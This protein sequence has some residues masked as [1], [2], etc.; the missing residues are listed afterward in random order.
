[1]RGTAYWALAVALVAAGPALCQVRVGDV[2]FGHEGHYREMHSTQVVVELINEGQTGIQGTAFVEIPGESGAPYR[3]TQRVEMPAQSH[4]RVNLYPYIGSTMMLDSLSVG[5]EPDRGSRSATAVPAEAEPLTDLLVLVCNESTPPFNF[6]RAIDTTTWMS[7]PGGGT[8]VSGVPG[9]GSYSKADVYVCWTTTSDLP[10][11]WK[12]LDDVDLLIMADFSPEALSPAQQDAILQWVSTGGRL[13]ITGGEDYRRVS[14]SFLA[15]YL[16]VNVT[17]ARTFAEGLP[18]LTTKFGGTMEAAPTVVTD[19]RPVRGFIWASQDGTP[20]LSSSTLGTG[21]L[22][23]A[24]FSFG[25]RPVLHW[26]GADDVISFILKRGRQYQPG[27]VGHHSDA[28]AASALSTQ[29]GPTPPSFQIISLFLLLYIVCLVPVNYLVLRK[30][31]RRELAWVTTP[32][33]VVVFSVA[34][35]ALGF[36]LKGNAVQLG[37]AGLFEI[38]ATTGAGHAQGYYALFSPRKHSYDISFGAERVVARVPRV[39]GSGWAGGFTE[40]A[41][42]DTPFQVASGERDQIEGLTVQMWDQKVFTARGPV[43]LEA[44]MPGDLR[45]DGQ[46]CLGG[47]L[48]NQLGFDLQGCVIAFRDQTTSLGDIPNGQ[49]VSVSMGPARQRFGHEPEAKIPGWVDSGGGLSHAYGISVMAMPIADPTLANVYSALVG[50]LPSG[51]GG[52]ISMYPSPGIAPPQRGPRTPE[53]LRRA[54]AQGF[55]HDNVYTL[56]DDEALLFGWCDHDPLGA[57]I[58]ALGVNREVLSIAVVHIPVVTE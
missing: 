15:P 36:V 21:M 12:G 58:G 9:G 25:R 56:R 16:P 50:Q 26:D 23:Q 22:W 24:A 18:R 33:I 28:E 51:G 46:Q 19:G 49:P 44:G 5:F 31:D 55:L 34:A 2:L 17:G 6:I 41:R 47:T 3:F 35:Y 30:L 39:R 29:T 57:D 11:S 43:I 53:T 45:V 52:G 42:L 7:A 40:E 13:L 4:K 14:E 38:Q 27:L 1:M 8:G 37:A 32:A 20:L 54:I 48:T 10:D